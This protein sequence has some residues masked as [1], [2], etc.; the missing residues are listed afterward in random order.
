MQ[1]EKNAKNPSKDISLLKLEL[2][3]ARK[4]EEILKQQLLEE[5]KRCED[6]EAEVVVDRKEL[7][8]FQ[9]LYHQNLF[10]IKAS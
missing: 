8:I 1:Y 10:S 2:E 5:R 9:A 7:K 3:E 4:I 6:L